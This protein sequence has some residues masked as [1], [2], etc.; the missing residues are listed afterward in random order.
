MRLFPYQ[1]SE[2]KEFEQRFSPLLP[3]LYRRA[4]NLTQSQH[5]AE[6]LLQDLLVKLLE[7]PEKWQHAEDL[8]TW[9]LR[10]LYNQF[11]DAWRKKKRSL[12]T[13]SLDD[14]LPGQAGIEPTAPDSPEQTALEGQQRESLQTA[15]AQLTP[16]FRT[17]LVLHDIEGHTLPEVQTLVDVPL[18]TLKSR[19][20]RARAQLRDQLKS[21]EPFSEAMR[22]NNKPCKN[23]VSAK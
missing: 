21:T 9:V 15:I 23:R 20:H 7:Q 22:V 14:S 4:Y 13:D 17:V 10:M 11:V 1:R 2:Q 12:L 8:K 3:I 6:E 5:D 18:G 19:L 16:E